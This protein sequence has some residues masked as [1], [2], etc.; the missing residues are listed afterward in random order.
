[1]YE[2]QFSDIKKPVK[3]PV[4]SAIP[5]AVPSDHLDVTVRPT[6]NFVT[7]EIAPGFRGNRDNSALGRVQNEA[8][9]GI[10]ELAD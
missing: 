1:M 2:E 9:V 3:R 7:H 8:G 10:N 5:R 6:S 4:L